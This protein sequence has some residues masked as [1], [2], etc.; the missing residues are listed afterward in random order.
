[1]VPVACIRAFRIVVL[2][3]FYFAAHACQAQDLAPRAYLITPIHSN[4]V[5]LTYSLFD[6]SLFFEGTVPITGATARVHVAILNYSH[7]LNFFGRTASFTASLP[8][9]VGNFRGTV[10]GAET[11]AYRSG[12]L[13]ATFR[14]SVNLIGGPA[15]NVPEFMKWR[16]RSI[17]GISIRLVPQAGQYDP[18]KLINLGSS[19]WAFKPEL[20][21]SQRWGHWTLDAYAGA[22]FYTTNP[23]FFSQNQFSPGINTQAQRPI[24]SFEGHLS[25]DFKPRL[26]MSLDGNYWFGGATSINGVLNAATLQRNSRVGGTASIPI[27]RHQSIKFS[28]SNGAYIR[29]GGSFQNVSLAWQYSWLGRP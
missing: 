15:M 6:G 13:P 26:W 28:Y 29:Y 12:L 24:G 18:T 11:L 7:S 25:Y 27:S 4:A 17:L 2:V 1:M 9:G 5:T 23:E 8:Y 19:R 10:V 16:Q 14:F 3:S 20:G 22:W 21:Y